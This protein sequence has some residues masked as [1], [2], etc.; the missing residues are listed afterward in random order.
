M[1]FRFSILITCLLLSLSA[2]FFAAPNTAGEVDQPHAVVETGHATDAADEQLAGPADDLWFTSLDFSS[3]G[4]K[5]EGVC[6]SWPVGS[7]QQ[8][9]LSVRWHRWLGVERC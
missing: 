2:E 3:P 9:L 6:L 5:L 7:M 4:V 8:H 1:N